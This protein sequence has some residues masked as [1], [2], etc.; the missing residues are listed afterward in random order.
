MV[1]VT[2]IAI[3]LALVTSSCGGAVLGDDRAG[4]GRNNPPQ[5][6]HR[7]SLTG[8]WGPLAVIADPGRGPLLRMEA[9]LANARLDVGRKCVVARSEN[10][11]HTTTLYWPERWT[12]WRPKTQ[13]IVFDNGRSSVRLRD[14]DWVDS[15]GGVVP[16]PPERWL[17]S[18]DPSCPR[19]HWV[20]NTI[21]HRQAG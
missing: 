6:D 3:A 13:T 18:P 17:S 4:S 11:R 20:V 9:L 2:L 16:I 1:K 8:R 5:G 14:G 15:G 21:Y 12:T 19:D 7:V 10:G